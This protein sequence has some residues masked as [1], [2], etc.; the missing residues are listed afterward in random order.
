MGKKL[1]R[2]A[3]IGLLVGGAFWYGKNKTKNAPTPKTE[4]VQEQSN[5]V[6]SEDSN[7]NSE[8]SGEEIIGFGQNNEGK[9]HENLGT[10]SS[11]VAGFNAVRSVEQKTVYSKNVT[12]L[13][14][15][16]YEWEIDVSDKSILTGRVNLTVVNSG[17]FSHNFVIKGVRDFGKLLPG[18]TKQFD[19]VYLRRG[20]FELLSDK[21]VDIQKGMK[22]V[23]VVE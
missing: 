21:S 7:E 4:V 16:L 18:E 15:Y 17:K 9:I 3:V 19:S 10:V 13:K 1:F 14:V 6:T 2:L 8:K 20:S 22:D 23:L 5:T 12:E 11:T